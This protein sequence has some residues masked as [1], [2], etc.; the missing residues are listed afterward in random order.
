[1]LTLRQNT[2]KF[3][4]VGHT[5]LMR[6]PTDSLNAIVLSEHRIACLPQ[7]PSQSIDLFRIINLFRNRR[8]ISKQGQT[9]IQLTYF[10]MTAEFRYGSVISK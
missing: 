1:M 4:E 7:F 10:E 2:L 9:S 3:N 6:S 8:D 5:E